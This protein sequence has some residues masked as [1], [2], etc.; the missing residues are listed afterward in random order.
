MES[1]SQDLTDRAFNRRIGEYKQ[2]KEHLEQQHSE[3]IVKIGE[4]DS[5]IKSLEKAIASKQG[6]LA[7][8][9]QRL[10]Q[11]KQRWMIMFGKITLLPTNLKIN[12]L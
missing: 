3:T 4:M 9:Q 8:C 1:L 5:S 11:R 6:P 7:T 10:Q 12:K 2:A